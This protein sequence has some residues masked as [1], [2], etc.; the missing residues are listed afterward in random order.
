MSNERMRRVRDVYNRFEAHRS[1][2]AGSLPPPPPPPP[3][4]THVDESYH[5]EVDHPGIGRSSRRYLMQHHHP[6]QHMATSHSHDMEQPADLSMKRE[7]STPTMVGVDLSRGSGSASS[8]RHHHSRSSSGNWWRNSEMSEEGVLDLASRPSRENNEIMDEPREDDVNANEVIVLSDEEAASTAAAG[9]T[10][11]NKL[12]GHVNGGGAVSED[13]RSSPIHQ[14]PPTVE[15]KEL[16]KE[17]VHQRERLIMKLKDNLRSEEMKLVLLKKL[18]LSHQ[19]KENLVVNSQSSS[20]KNSAT[21]NNINNNISGVN[22]HNSNSR[23]P[24]GGHMGSGVNSGNT[25]PPLFRGQNS[26]LKSTGL[27]SSHHLIPP[28]VRPHN[29][30][31]PPPLVQSMNRNNSNN[32]STSSHHPMQQQPT[33]LM[34]SHHGSSSISHRPPVTTPPNVVMGYQLPPTQAQGKMGSMV[35]VSTPSQSPSMSLQSSTPLYSMES[36]G[37]G[38]TP[39]Q[40]QAAAKLALRKQLEKTLLQIP[41]PKP[42]PPELHFIPNP[43]NT[44]FIYL[45]GLES[46]VN[47][48]TEGDRPHEDEAPKPFNCVQCN[49]DF[50]PVWKWENTKKGTVICEQ[51]VTSNIKKALKAEHTNRLKTAFVKALQQEQEIEQRMSQVST[52]PTTPP[53]SSSNV[54]PPPPP[55]PQPSAPVLQLPKMSEPLRHAHVSNVAASSANTHQQLLRLPLHQPLPAHMLTSLSPFLAQAYQ[56]QV[57]GKNSVTTSELQRQYL[58]DMIPPRSLPPGPMN[59]NT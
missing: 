51:C 40:R 16:T 5:M 59:W 11:N 29:A 9:S 38:Q 6:S 34:R 50:T 56:Y 42:P 18:Q 19:M 4:I 39:A 58:L 14:V 12:N 21:Y 37:D 15:L 44:E 33:N 26:I 41:P 24:G 57:L 27:H 7:S 1:G 46:V 2:N 23:I 55:P 8:S 3:P 48:I 47:F 31:G 45:V 35:N 52:S 28:L 20:G 25:P 22:S 53:P 17:E 30:H 54:P 32:S 43:S 36:R 10:H 13:E 49:T